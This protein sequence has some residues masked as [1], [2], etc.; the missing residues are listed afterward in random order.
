MEEVKPQEPSPGH[1][2]WME[3]VIKEEFELR[4]FSWDFLSGLLNRQPMNGPLLTNT[5]L[6][7]VGWANRHHCEDRWKR[8]MNGQ[9]SLL[10]WR[11]SL[12]TDFVNGLHV[13]ECSHPSINARSFPMCI[14]KISNNRRHNSKFFRV[15]MSFSPPSSYYYL[16]HNFN[17]GVQLLY[18]SHGNQKD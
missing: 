12:P 10:L 17:L 9:C 14:L 1:L 11:I 15:E 6:L 18:L 5:A 3:Q 8:N 4:S 2:W 16:K 7:H 13:W